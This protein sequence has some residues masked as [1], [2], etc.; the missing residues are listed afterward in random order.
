MQRVGILV[1][2]AV[3]DRQTKVSC[4]YWTVGTLVQEKEIVWLHIS[5]DDPLCMALSNES[6]HTSYNVCY[7][8]LCKG[9]VL[10]SVQN[11]T[12]LTK[13]HD[14]VD[15]AWVLVYILHLKRLSGLNVISHNVISRTVMIADSR[16]IGVWRYLCRYKERAD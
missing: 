13:L 5:E 10:D 15:I 12:T 16:E 11:A 7:L 6:E 3:P 4:S 9:S 1:Y 8:L 14:H 2:D